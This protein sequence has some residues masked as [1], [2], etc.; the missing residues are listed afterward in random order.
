MCSRAIWDDFHAYRDYLGPAI[1]CA[2]FCRIPTFYRAQF[3][4]IV[5][6]R[7][8]VAPYFKPLPLKKNALKQF[9]GGFRLLVTMTSLHTACT[10]PRFVLVE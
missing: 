8:V 4:Q 2:L 1:V 5:H 10:K 9:F 3:E 6:G 7:Q